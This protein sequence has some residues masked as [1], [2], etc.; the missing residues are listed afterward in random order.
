MPD[1]EPNSDKSDSVLTYWGVENIE[2]AVRS[3]L[4]RGA[5]AHEAPMNV[6]GEIVVA[7]VKDPWCNV[8]GLIY[9]PNFEL[10]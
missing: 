4:E 6:G 10:P 1:A 7:S 8:L 9:N 3:F 5:T 2:V